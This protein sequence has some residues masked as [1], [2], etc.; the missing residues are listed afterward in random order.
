MSGLGHQHV[1]ALIHRWWYQTLF[2]Q[3][4]SHSP[5]HQSDLID[6]SPVSNQEPSQRPPSRVFPIP[7]YQQGQ[8]LFD[9]RH[10]RPIQ[11]KERRRLYANYNHGIFRGFVVPEHKWRRAQLSFVRP[12][13]QLGACQLLCEAQ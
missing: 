1:N 6:M 2:N 5:T 9:R 13:S 11:S 10:Y 4:I 8:S 3:T 7:F 12:Q